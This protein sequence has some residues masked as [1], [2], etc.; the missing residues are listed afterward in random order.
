MLK[1]KT[2]ESFDGK[3]NIYPFQQTLA[4]FNLLAIYNTKYV[5]KL[6]NWSVRGKRKRSTHE[7]RERERR[8]HTGVYT[9]KYTSRK[10]IKV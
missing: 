5:Q 4:Q 3:R 9:Y 7:E 6:L 2:L 1:S 10:H 8:S